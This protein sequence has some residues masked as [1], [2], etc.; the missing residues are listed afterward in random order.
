ML[1]YV[2]FWENTCLVN[3]RPIQGLEHLLATPI[4]AVSVAFFLAVIYYVAP[5]WARILREEREKMRVS[6]DQIDGPR[7]AVF[8]GFEVACWLVALYFL[9]QQLGYCLQMYG[10]DRH[11]PTGSIILV[12]MAVA[13][14]VLELLCRVLTAV[15][16]AVKPHH[17]YDLPCDKIT[18]RTY[19]EMAGRAALRCFVMFNLVEGNAYWFFFF[20]LVVHSIE[21]V[22]MMFTRRPVPG[23]FPPWLEWQ[24]YREAK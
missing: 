6:S 22:S 21:S 13:L 14:L 2:R 5:L 7:F 24:L 10:A 19:Q 15:A 9:P 4:T 16:P 17:A 11:C 23:I 8:V 18:A 1:C 20:W 3:M 12:E